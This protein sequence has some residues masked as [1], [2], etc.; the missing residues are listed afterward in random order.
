ML[1]ALFYLFFVLSCFVSLISLTDTA[2]NGE[3]IKAKSTGSK[4]ERLG[5]K[6]NRFRYKSIVD[7]KAFCAYLTITHRY[8]ANNP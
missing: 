5:P 1:G 3:T 8:M 7:Q 2:G 4:S 6:G